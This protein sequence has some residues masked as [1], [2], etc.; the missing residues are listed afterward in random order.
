MYAELVETH[1]VLAGDGAAGRDAHAH[2]FAHRR[3]HPRALVGIAAVV[4]HVRVQVAVAGVKD[5]A[6]PDAL[7]GARSPR[8]VAS[9]SGE[10]RAR[11]HGVLD[12][13]GAARRGPSRRTPSCGP[14]RGARAPPRRVRCGSSRA[15]RL[16]ADA[17]GRRRMSSSSPRDRAIH[18]DE[19]HRR[20]VARIA[21]GVDRGLDGLD[22]CRGPSVS[23]AVGTM[24]AAMIALTSRARRRPRDVKSASIV[25]T[26]SGFGVSRTVIVERDAEASLRADE[27]AEQVVALTRSPAG[28]AEPHHLAVGQHDRRARARD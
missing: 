9:T 10:L 26:A 22:A 23:S 3:A 4:G 18:L 16:A 24:P 2:D 11:H 1:A 14:A 15:P 21:R 8:C 28:V 12:R 25:R 6:D 5:V 27:R 19:Q 17:L 7:A 13:R 20:G